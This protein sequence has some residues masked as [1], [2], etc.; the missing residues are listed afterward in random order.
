MKVIYVEWLD[1]VAG[2]GWQAID[3]VDGIH[4]C[5]TIGYLIKED[6]SYIVLA[7]TVSDNESNCRLSI[8]TAWIKKRKNIKI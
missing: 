1:A 8:P 4:L 2:C 7:S 3:L 5:K 6:P